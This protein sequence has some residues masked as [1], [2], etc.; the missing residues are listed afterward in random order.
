MNQAVQVLDGYQILRDRR[1][2]LINALVNGAMI[3]CI[4]T[5][6]NPDNADEFYNTKQFDLEELLTV[7]IEEEKYNSR[8][9]VECSANQFKD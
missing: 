9:E 7:Y 1:S 4:V 2:L 3:N 8:G 5:D 6:I